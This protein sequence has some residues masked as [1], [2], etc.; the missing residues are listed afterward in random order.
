MQTARAL[1]RSHV[2]NGGT[3]L[4]FQDRSCCRVF[5][6]R[7]LLIWGPWGQ[8]RASAIHS[9]TVEARDVKGPDK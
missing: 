1:L 5:R 2:V 9:G 6:D 7:I 4:A 3:G 8:S